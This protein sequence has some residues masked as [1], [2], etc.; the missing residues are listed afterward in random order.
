VPDALSL[1]AGS[2]G[3]LTPEDLERVHVQDQGSQ[4]IARV[5]RAAPGER[6]LDLCASPGGKTMII[7]SDLGLTPDTPAAGLV[8]SDHRPRRIRLLT[9]TLR[10]ARLPV[11]LVSLDARQSL[12]FGATFDA[13]LIDAPCS[14]LGTLSRD[15]DLKWS[16]RVDQL[17]TLAADQRRIL[18]AAADAVRPGGR[19]VYA[20]CSSEPEE[21]IEIVE[22]FLAEDERFAISPI[23][24]PAV[25][26]RMVDERG[27]LV[28]LPHRD[29]ID[30]FFAALLVRRKRT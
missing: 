27:C 15:P 30:A 24:A 5:V 28:T 3:R 26:P 7:A 16:R 1:P 17:P 2:L 10:R 11:P 18:R 29:G 9:D 14:G 23:T 8:A 21:N 4:L 12:P 19:L 25:P 13:V 22:S 6:V 20:T